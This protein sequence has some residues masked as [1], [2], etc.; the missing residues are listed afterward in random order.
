MSRILVVDDDIASCRT[1]AL[2]LGGE[3]HEVRVAHTFEDGLAAARAAAP[4]LVIL[5][6]RIPGKGGL[7]GLRDLKREFPNTPVIMITAFPRPGLP[8]RSHGTRGGRLHRQTGGPQRV[9][10]SGG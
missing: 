4:Q 9:G 8:T 1:M 3:G 6:I 10:R 2:H 5:D 7:E